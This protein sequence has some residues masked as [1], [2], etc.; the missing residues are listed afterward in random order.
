MKILAKIISLKLTAALNTWV[1]LWRSGRLRRQQEA[2]LERVIR[3]R[4]VDLVGR[5]FETWSE[6]VSDAVEQTHI[7]EMREEIFNLTIRLR[8]YVPPAK[9]DFCRVLHACVSYP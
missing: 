9:T 1:D 2:K 7:L 5:H 8:R 6:H 4:Y 3:R